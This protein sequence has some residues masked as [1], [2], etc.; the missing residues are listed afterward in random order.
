DPLTDHHQVVGED[1]KARVPQDAASL[2][3]PCRWASAPLP[4][5]EPRL[6]VGAAI[7]QQSPTPT[8]AG[9]LRCLSLFVCLACPPGALLLM[10]ISSI[11]WNCQ[12]SRNLLSMSRYRPSL[13][14]FTRL[15]G[16]APCIPVSRQLTG[17]GLTPVSAFR[18]IDRGRSSF[19]F[20]SVVGGEK[21]GRFSFL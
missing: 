14:E 12:C 3:S 19:L 9:V 11:R 16:S 1:R 17:D 7:M 18:L 13:E 6:A 2:R 20:E 8:E 10:Y 21:V 5:P 15:V 4:G